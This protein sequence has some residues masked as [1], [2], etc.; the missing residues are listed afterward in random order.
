LPLDSLYS[1]Q[2]NGMIKI[3]HAE[4]DCLNTKTA[5]QDCK[6]FQYSCV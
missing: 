5:L 2:S 3:L 6:V 1:G 4:V